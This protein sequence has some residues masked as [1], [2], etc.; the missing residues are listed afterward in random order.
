MFQNVSHQTH[1]TTQFQY[2]VKHH[3]LYEK[4]GVE[5]PKLFTYLAKFNKCM[6]ID[7]YP[8]HDGLPIKYLEQT[9][10]AIRTWFNEYLAHMKY[11][12]TDKSSAA[13]HVL[14]AVS[15]LTSIH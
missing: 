14:E 9:Q 6:S 13:N 1:R 4:A 5:I 12:R 2:I 11:R 10:R 3:E 8:W 15:N 7:C